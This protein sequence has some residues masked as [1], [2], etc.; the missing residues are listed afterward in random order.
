MN[1]PK[2][3]ATEVSK[4][5]HC[6]GRQ[7]YKCKHF[8]RPSLSITA[9][10]SISPSVQQLCLTMYLNGMGLRGMERVTEI[11]HTTVMH[12]HSRGPTSTARCPNI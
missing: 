1:C 3:N 7:Y 4:N 5:G 6:Q 9:A 12:A 8:G 11:H 10:S 2:C